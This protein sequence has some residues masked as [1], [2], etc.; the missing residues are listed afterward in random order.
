MANF[1]GVLLP[2]PFNDV[3]DYK[4][5]KDLSLGQIVRVPFLKGSQV[6][7]VYKLGKSSSLEDKKIK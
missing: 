5:D 6:G 1:I 7:V 2:L 3:F 4:T